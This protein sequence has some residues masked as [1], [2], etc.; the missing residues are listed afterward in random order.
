MTTVDALPSIKEFLAL[1]LTK[2]MARKQAITHTRTWVQ[3]TAKFILHIAG[4]SCLTLA[5]FSWNI[6]AGFIVAGLSFLALATWFNPTPQPP[7]PPRMR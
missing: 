3:A 4:L 1:K 5:G 7:T 2:T 6:I